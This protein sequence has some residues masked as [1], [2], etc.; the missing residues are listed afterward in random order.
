MIKSLNDRY[1]EMQLKLFQ[2][3]KPFQ[4]WLQR[5]EEWPQYRLEE[6]VVSDL[7][8]F[9]SRLGFSKFTARVVDVSTGVELPGIVVLRG[10]S[11]AVM[12]VV[13][14]SDNPSIPN[15]VMLTKQFRTAM[16]SE[17]VETVA[18]MMDDSQQVRGKALDELKE[19]AGIEL[20]GDKLVNLTEWAGMKEGL[21][22]SPGLVDERMHLL[23]TEL[24]L[25]EKEIGEFRDQQHGVLEEGE[26]IRLE[27][28]NLEDAYQVG[29]AK[30]LSALLLYDKYQK[31]VRE[32]AETIRLCEEESTQSL[33]WF[34]VGI[35]LTYVINSIFDNR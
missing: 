24:L 8:M 5:Y 13:R 20:D 1:T 18:G 33:F 31:R 3:S 34:I 28:V 2:E 17:V 14:C 16:S 11:V 9:G 6:V 26:V 21:L 22:V 10:D 30:L 12:V 29:D 4:K 15:K 25:T 35:S 19:E 7:D 32:P 27:T 23:F